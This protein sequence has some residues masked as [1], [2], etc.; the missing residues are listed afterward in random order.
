[1]EYI[2]TPWREKYVKNVFKMK[3][4]KDEKLI[5]AKMIILKIFFP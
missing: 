3:N 4:N 1:M 2:V 5:F